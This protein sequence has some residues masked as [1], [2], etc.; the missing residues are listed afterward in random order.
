MKLKLWAL[1]NNV[2]ILG[3]VNLTVLMATKEGKVLEFEEEAYVVPGM[4]VPILLG[5]DFQDNYNVSIHRDEGEVSLS[6]KR[7]GVEH[8]VAASNSTMV[9]KGF[10]VHRV[11]NAFSRRKE[12]ER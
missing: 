6:L 2:R 10:E 5:E 1:T 12:V 3:Y 4:N 8:F 7:D 9:D 11:E